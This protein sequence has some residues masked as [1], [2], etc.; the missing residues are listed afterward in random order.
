VTLAEAGDDL[1]AAAPRA[2]T[3]SASRAARR[4]SSVTGRWHNQPASA[5]GER[6]TAGALRALDRSQRRVSHDV[7]A[8]YCCL[9]WTA[10][11]RTRC[12]PPQLPRLAQSGS[13]SSLKTAKE[14][15][16]RARRIA[17]FVAMLGRGDTI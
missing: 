14:P 6:M 1:Q 16:T 5:E 12:G 8:E 9:A 2:R 17:A 15:E 7:R 4:A 3:P 11:A 13:G 10:A